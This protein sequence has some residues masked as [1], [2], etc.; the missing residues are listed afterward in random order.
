MGPIANEI[1]VVLP[2]TA[3]LLDAP[4]LAVVEGIDGVPAGTHLRDRSARSPA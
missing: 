1:G 3:L 4:D 2:F